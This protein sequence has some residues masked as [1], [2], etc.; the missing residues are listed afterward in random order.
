LDDDDDEVESTSL[1]FDRCRRRAV[2]GV[3]QSGL[4]VLGLLLLFPLLVFL[5]F[6]DAAIVA[7]K[8][9][10]SFLVPLRRNGLFL[11]PSET[12]SPIA[13]AVATGAAAAPG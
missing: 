4:L 7:C 3:I 1:S 11:G 8:A 12:R 6:L 9:D 2:L 10:G 5:L 13:P